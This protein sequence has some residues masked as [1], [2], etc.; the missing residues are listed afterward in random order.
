M[1]TDAQIIEAMEQKLPYGGVGAAE[2]VHRFLGRH[3]GYIYDGQLK[4]LFRKLSAEER[5]LFAENFGLTKT[6][7][8]G[9][10]RFDG[11]LQ[12]NQ[13]LAA[14]QRRL[15]EGCCPIHAIPMYQSGSWAYYD[16]NG[17]EVPDNDCPHC[18][19]CQALAK[20]VRFMTT[21]QCLVCEITARLEEPE[22]PKSPYRAHLDGK[23][24]HLLQ[25]PGSAQ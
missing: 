14:R 25:E 19:H 24:L 13:S 7:V 18:P 1:L 15:A 8:N 10:V 23:F 4:N 9:K 17:N 6:T 3:G 2:T 11:D 16:E 21:A 5:A 22:G 12:S 20:V